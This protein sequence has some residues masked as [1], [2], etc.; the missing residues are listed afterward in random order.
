[1]P[2]RWG[3]PLR[4]DELFRGVRAAG[5]GIDRWRDLLVTVVTPPGSPE[6]A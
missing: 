3:V 1:M 5:Q 4:A 2:E 6:A